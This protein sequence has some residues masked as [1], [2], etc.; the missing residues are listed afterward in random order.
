MKEKLAE[1]REDLSVRW[2]MMDSQQ[3]QV[4]LLGTLALWEGIVMVISSRAAKKVNNAE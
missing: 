4:I 3:K 1:I 2:F